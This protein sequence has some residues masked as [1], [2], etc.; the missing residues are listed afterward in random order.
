MTLG[1]NH[2]LLLAGNKGEDSVQLE[3]LGINN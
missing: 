2:L 1:F 3:D